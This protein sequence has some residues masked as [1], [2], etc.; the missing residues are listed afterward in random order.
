[1]TYAVEP[2]GVVHSPRSGRDDD[3]WGSVE[4]TIVLDERFSPE[5]F[6]GLEAFSHLEVVFLLHEIAESEI[7]QTARRPRNNP[8][9]PRVGIFAQ[10]GAKRPNRIGVSRCRLLRV[11]GRTLYVRGLDAIEGSPVLDVKPYMREFAPGA[12]VQQPRWATEIMTHYYD[13]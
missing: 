9:W 2:I 10:R 4:S 8:A 7:E 5:A 1:M 13:G 3:Y 11:D 12:G 6:T